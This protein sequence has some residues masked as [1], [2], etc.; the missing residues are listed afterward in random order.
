MKKET[1][2]LLAQLGLSQNGAR[3]YLALLDTGTSAISDIAR[4]SKI[5]RPLVYKALPELIE[6]NLVTKVPKGKRTQY[7]ATSPRKLRQIYEHMGNHL[8]EALPLLEENFAKAGNRPVVT[9][10][11]GRAGII[12]VYEDILQTLPSGGVFYRYSSS[13]GD[14]K[15]IYVP[16][17]Y[18]TRRDAKQIERY[19]ITNKTS[20]E[21]KKGKRDLAVK[22]IPHGSD[23]FAYNITQLM[24]GDKV[25]FVDYNSE[26]AIIIENPIIA[27]F[28][29]RLFKLLYQRL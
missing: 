24:Y 12:S 25:A 1:H 2:T 18:S 21:R 6:K 19:V 23:L 13:K 20:A 4:Q 26:T 9:Y 8:F 7:A 14:R 17:D 22:A 16:K 29:E 10:L 3:V 11:E 28:Q 5:E 27:K 15:R